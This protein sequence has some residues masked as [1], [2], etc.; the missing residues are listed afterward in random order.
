MSGT[1]AFDFIVVREF[2]ESLERDYAE[3][4]H[5]AEVHAWKSVQVLAGSIVESLLIDYL[6]STTHP[7]RPEKDPL[8]LDLASA[9]GVCRAENAISART[10]DLCSVIRSYRNLIHPGRVVRLSE[11]PPSAKTAQIAVALVGLIIEDIALARRQSLGLTAEQVLSKL[12]QDENSVAILQHLL[13]DVPAP[14]QARLLLELIPDKYCSLVP[15]E[16]EWDQFTA[17]R[18]QQAHR[19]VFNKVSDDIRRAAAAEFVRVLR[20]EDGTQV[21]RYREAFFKPRDLQYVASNQ[22][23]MVRQHLLS[24]VPRLH[25]VHTLRFVDG[26]ASYLDPSEVSSWI[27]PYICTLLLPP[28][29]EPVKAKVKSHLLD[30]TLETSADSDNAIDS[31]L[32]DWIRHLKKSSSEDVPS[33]RETQGRNCFAAIA[34]RY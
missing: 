32:D 31:R 28:E 24:L 25:S 11:S 34:L 22:A 16:D 10:A 33:D 18:L 2:R 7:G 30:A 12:V 4:Q 23:S 15:A 8:G 29:K 5:C 3:M 14:Q 1:V 21:N 17:D 19:I 27:D 13:K 20:E 6:A 9:L 26:I